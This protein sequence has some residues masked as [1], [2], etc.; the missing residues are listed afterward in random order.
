VAADPSGLRFSIANASKDLG[1][2]N[3]MAAD[4]NAQRAIAAAVL[5]TLEQALTQAPP[6]ALLPELAGLLAR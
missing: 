3:T 4:A 5:G 2:Y 6:G 1:Y